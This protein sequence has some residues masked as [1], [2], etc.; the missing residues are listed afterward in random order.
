MDTWKISYSGH[1]LKVVLFWHTIKRERASRT[2]QPL[3]P[4]F[5]VS[6]IEGN[7][8]KQIFES[9]VQGI[10]HYIDYKCIV[11]SNLIYIYTIKC[12]TL[13]QTNVWHFY[14]NFFKKNIYTP[15][16]AFPCRVKGNVEW[17]ELLASLLHL[18]ARMLLRSQRFLALFPVGKV[19]L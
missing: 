15:F 14:A 18:C 8:P 16:F 6:E 17:Y 4:M 19:R 13:L 9:I 11:I 10:F 5:H 3:K 7:N 1:G 2:L 12:N